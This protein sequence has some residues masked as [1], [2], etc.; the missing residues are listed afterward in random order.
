MFVPPHS[1]LLM[2]V[3]SCSNET[4][5]PTPVVGKFTKYFYEKQHSEAHHYP[6]ELEEAGH[7]FG[8]LPVENLEHHHVED[9]ASR[10]AL[11]GG[12]HLPRDGAGL[13]LGDDDA[14]PDTQ[15]ADEAEHSE[16]GEEDE[17]LGS[18]LLELQTDTEVDDEL[19]ESDG[20]N[21]K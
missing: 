11:Q 21:I 5:L 20:C 15:G 9:G 3:L 17:L 18:V 10:H 12:G 13:Q 16:V 4:C 1:S 8:S 14:D 6:E 7:V 19:V 2:F